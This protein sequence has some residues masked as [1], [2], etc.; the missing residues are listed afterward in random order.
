MKKIFLTFATAALLSVNAFA[1]DGG[2][3]TN[4]TVAN[5]SYS[6]QQQFT[7]D[8]ANA[9]NT[10]WT[11]DRNCQKADFTVD[12]VQKTAFYSLGNDFLGITTVVT[13]KAIP[14]ASQKMIADHYKDY[15]A[16]SVIIYQANEAVTTDIEPTTYFVDLKSSAHELLVRV[17]ASGN[18]EFF[19]QVK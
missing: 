15:T 18:V 9:Q 12:G 17:T 1:A 11:V 5:V 4:E 2:K 7:N 10:V 6:V 19:K 13:Y 8:F 16:K 3:K 14:A